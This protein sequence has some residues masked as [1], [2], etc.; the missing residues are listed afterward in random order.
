[1]ATCH[2][3]SFQERGSD[4]DLHVGGLLGSALGINNYGRVEVA[5]LVEEKLN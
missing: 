5:G 3:S 4:S 1:M 2:R